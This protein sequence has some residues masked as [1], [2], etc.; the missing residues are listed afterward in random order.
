MNM[1]LPPQRKANNYS[2]RRID[3][4]LTSTVIICTFFFLLINISSITTTP[5]E[6]V[7]VEGITYKDTNL[8]WAC[9]KG[10]SD[11]LCV[12]KVR[13]HAHSCKMYGSEIQMYRQIYWSKS[14][15]LLFPSPA[16]KKTVEQALV[17]CGF[18]I[19]GSTKLI[20]TSIYTINLF[21]ISLLFVIIIL[22][23]FIFR[24]K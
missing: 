14:E 12:R 23:P 15:G 1:L 5:N 17:S 7:F 8:P 3:P 2:F 4:L 11:P 9:G 22:I 19:L 18:I 16:K 13:Q 21:F 24:R 20:D 6:T 10:S